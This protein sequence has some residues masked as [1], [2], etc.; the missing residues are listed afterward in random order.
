MAD[1]EIIISRM[2]QRRGNRI[3]LPQPLRAGEV[4]LAS[5]S[6][7]VFIGLDPKI[8]VTA[9]NA[10]SVSVNNII[11]GF[12]YANSYLNNNF[13][14]L[15]MPS[16]RFPTSTFD[17]TANNTTFVVTGTSGQAHSHPVF[18]ASITSG[19]I[20]NVFDGGA[21]ESTDFTGAKNGV[22]LSTNA[23]RTAANLLNNEFFVSSPTTH[24]NTTLTFGSNPTGSDDITL[25]YYSN[26]DI[27]SAFTDAGNVGST[28]TVGFYDDKNVASYRQ[29]N[30][31][32]IRSDYEVGTAFVGMENKHVEVFAESSTISASITGLT[33]I[34]IKRN[35]NNVTTTVS[36]SGLGTLQAVVNAVNN[37]NIF[38]KAT[39][40]STTNWYVSADE[41]FEI[42]YT[43]NSDGALLQ[44]PHQA[45]TRAL[46]S[47]K[48]QLEDW[49]HGSLGDATFNMFVAA[50]V[51]NKFNSGATRI[52][53]FTPSTSSEN[54]SITMTGNQEAENFSTITNKI[55]GASAN[56]VVTGLTNVKTN[57][58]LLTQDDYSV[59]LTGSA[60]SL[61]EAITKSC[62][63]GSTDIVSF[64]AVD[65]TAVIIEY[66]VTAVGSSGNAY[67]RTGTLHLTANQALQDASLNDTG[68]VMHNG[69][70]ASTFDLS[71]TYDNGTNTFKLTSTNNL[72]D[73]TTRTASFKYLVRK[74]LG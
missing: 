8:G 58:R 60:N 27:I 30:N 9:Q 59:L 49:I 3:D 56:A 48:G 26:A 29:F 44:L 61:F 67:S 62:P 13:V 38:A 1:K 37:A 32:Y 71:T 14:R 25:N 43:D 6:K 50:E 36:L 11:N 5:D 72:T 24:T 35:S 57:Q 12:T 19:N 55:F 51:G 23:T 52:S 70:G 17:G 4:A 10:N 46:N 7:E 68:A 16:K 42:S 39:F 65:V 63:P 34:K 69:F 41:E 22:A 21:F 66:S 73:G 28:A 53:K 54:L 2:Q 45:Y 40:I 64:G 20:K 47:I 33:D 74:W 15:I 31:A 18:N